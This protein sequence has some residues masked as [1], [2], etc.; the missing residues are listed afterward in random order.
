M[1]SVN[2]KNVFVI[3]AV[4]DQDLDQTQLHVEAA[5]TVN[6]DLEAI[7]DQGKDIAHLLQGVDV[8]LT[9]A[10]HGLNQSQGRHQ[11]Q[12]QSLFHALDQDLLLVHDHA[13]QLK[14]RGL[15]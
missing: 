11:S 9:G 10:N 13:P 1:L 5:I 8:T 3:G 4:G 7:A 15:H 6:H 2:I 14:E 12:G